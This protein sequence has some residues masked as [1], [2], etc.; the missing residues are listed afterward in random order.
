MS[1]APHP[2]FEFFI[3]SNN[4]RALDIIELF[5]YF[6]FH[7]GKRYAYANLIVD[8]NL[9]LINAVVIK[10]QVVELHYMICLYMLARGRRAEFYIACNGKQL[11]A[12]SVYQLNFNFMLSLSDSALS[13]SSLIMSCI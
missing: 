6:D 2:A 1:S 9:K 7:N 13:A 5:V 11:M 3:F 10:L 12:V 8:E 4:F